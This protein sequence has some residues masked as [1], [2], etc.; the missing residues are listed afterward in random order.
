LLTCVVVV[1][2]LGSALGAEALTMGGQAVAA[3]RAPTATSGQL[4]V[5]APQD[6]SANAVPQPGCNCQAQK[7]LI[8]PPPK[9]NTPLTP[10][11]YADSPQPAGGAP[12]G[13]GKVV[14]VSIAQQW[15]WGYQGGKLVLASPVTT[16]M[17]QLPTPRGTFSV[18]VK[19]ENTMFYSPWPQGSPYYYTPEHVNYAL[20]FRS[21]GFF[22]HDAPWRKCFGPGTNVPHTCPGATVPETGSHGCVNMPTPTGAW[23]YAWAPYGTT[24]IIR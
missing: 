17:P 19:A 22:L 20:E 1:L 12:G 10:L 15:M 9:P 16:G 4:V 2:A 18:F 6:V 23:L 11:I 5:S 3:P 21:G 13:A 8:P 24:V 7:R 14:L